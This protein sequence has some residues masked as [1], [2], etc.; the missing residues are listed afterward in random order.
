MLRIHRNVIQ[1]TPQVR[2]AAEL[3][4]L[5]WDEGFS[6]F[7]NVYPLRER[8]GKAKIVTLALAVCWVWLVVVRV[9]SAHSNS[10]AFLDLTGFGRAGKLYKLPRSDS[11]WGPEVGVSDP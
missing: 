8:S 3:P 10:A 7:S 11:P 2:K 5:K 6:F 1:V 9:A 4:G